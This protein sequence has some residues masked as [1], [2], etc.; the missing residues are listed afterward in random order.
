MEDEREILIEEITNMI[1]RMD[2]ERLKL[3]FLFCL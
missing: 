1:E 3:I 2:A